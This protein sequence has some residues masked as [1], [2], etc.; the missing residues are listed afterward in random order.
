MM[1]EAVLNERK[2]RDLR[3]RTKVFALRIIRLY[4]ALPKTAEARVFGG[5]MLIH[6]SSFIVHHFFRED[7]HAVCNDRRSN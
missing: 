2:R 3:A 6:H 1:N 7:A 4:A 5:Q